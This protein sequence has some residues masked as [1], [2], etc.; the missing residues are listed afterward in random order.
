[1][2]IC[3]ADFEEL[4]PYLFAPKD[5][6]PLSATSSASCL[7]RGKDYGGCTTSAKIIPLRCDWRYRKLDVAHSSK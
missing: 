1:M 6:Q 3:K 5:I 4:F 2:M 7:K